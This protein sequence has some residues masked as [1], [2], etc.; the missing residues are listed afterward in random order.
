[1]TY[2]HPLP[3]GGTLTAEI[4]T[5]SEASIKAGLAEIARVAA[6]VVP[7]SQV[8]AVVGEQAVAILERLRDLLGV[9]SMGAVEAEVERMVGQTKT[10]PD[11]VTEWPPD[12]L[13]GDWEYHH[14]GV[15]AGRWPAPVGAWKPG[16]P[17]FVGVDGGEW[18]IDDFADGERFERVKEGK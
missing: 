2:A 14:G 7:V 6:L 1:M 10:T 3:N 16:P 5:A 9:A 11:V 15:I 4:S 13:S 12:Q 18:S 17:V 8:D